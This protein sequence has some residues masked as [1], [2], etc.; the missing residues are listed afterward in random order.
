MWDS[1]L[2]N[3]EKGKGLTVQQCDEMVVVVVGML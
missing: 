3:W 2:E 1:D